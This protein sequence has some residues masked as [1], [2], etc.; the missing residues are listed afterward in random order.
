MHRAIPLIHKFINIQSGLLLY[1]VDF[2]DKNVRKLHELS[3]F[4]HFCGHL[5]LKIDYICLFFGINLFFHLFFIYNHN[6]TFLYK[7]LFFWINRKLHLF[8]HFYLHIHSWDF[9]LSFI[10]NLLGILSLKKYSL[11][12][13]LVDAT[14]K[15]FLSSS[16]S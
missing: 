11:C 1:K 10:K 3:T 2:F 12:R 16:F 14:Y 4:P 15:R 9:P 13:A 5:I 8:I 6:L 7:I